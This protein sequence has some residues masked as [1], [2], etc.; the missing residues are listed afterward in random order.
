M[1]ATMTRLVRPGSVVWLTVA[2]LVYAMS[3]YLL[4]GNLGG[5]YEWDGRTIEPDPEW[6]LAQFAVATVGFGFAVGGAAS[7]SRGGLFVAWL[8][9]GAAWL[10]LTLV[11][12]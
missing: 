3:I 7:R 2:G 9:A 1:R 8:A 11:W 4:I 10:A 12:P 5:P 6:G